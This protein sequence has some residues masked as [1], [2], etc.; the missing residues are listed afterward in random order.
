MHAVLPST[1]LTAGN[2]P[3]IEPL[4]DH[5]PFLLHAGMCS[6]YRDA[7]TVTDVHPKARSESQLL[8]RAPGWDQANIFGFLLSHY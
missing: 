4:N 3:V 7:A 8:L 2:E 1:I 6:Y 5:E